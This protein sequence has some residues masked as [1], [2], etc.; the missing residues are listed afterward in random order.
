MTEHVNV[1]T[2]ENYITLNFFQPKIKTDLEITHDR[3]ETMTV[4]NRSVTRHVR[5]YTF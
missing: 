4:K 3:T 2:N 1:G 5:R